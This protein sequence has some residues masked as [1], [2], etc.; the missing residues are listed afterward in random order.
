[1]LC[2][3]YIPS[4]SPKFGNFCFIFPT[5][6]FDEKMP[7]CFVKLS[8]TENFT[9][10]ISVV[11]YTCADSALM[12]SLAREEGNS[13]GHKGLFFIQLER[14]QN[15]ENRVVQQSLTVL[16]SKHKPWKISSTPFLVPNPAQICRCSYG[17]AQ[18]PEYNLDWVGLKSWT[19]L[20]LSLDCLQQGFELTWALGHYTRDRFPCQI[21]TNQPRESQRPRMTRSW[22]S[23]TSRKE[24]RLLHPTL[25]LTTF[26][27]PN[28]SVAL[29]GWEIFVLE[30]LSPYFP[31]RFSIVGYM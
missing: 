28:E 21:G 17:S 3:P 15:W 20:W 16:W 18:S 2:L 25:V 12:K 26:L 9:R 13:L 7:I 8:K 11:V 29:W 23:W 14:L 1:M 27:G 6:D 19:Q 10:H 31:M 4:L 22:W 24:S 5:Y 30:S